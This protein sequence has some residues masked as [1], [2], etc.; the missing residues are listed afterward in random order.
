M[1]IT[2]FTRLQFQC[3][4]SLITRRCFLLALAMLAACSIG[5]M[6][7]R[8]S[9]VFAQT[10]DASQQTML[11]VTVS[12]ASFAPVV[13]P[14]SIAAAFG[15]RLA[16]RTE[17]AADRPLP[18]SLAGTT[19][20][21]N[22]ELAP[23]FFVSPGQ[24]NYLIP[25]GT[26]PGAASVVVTA[27]DGAVSTGSA[28]IGAVAPALFTANSDGQGA[29]ASL[30]YRVKANGQRIYEPLSRYDGASFVTRPIDFGAESDQLFLVLYL[31]GIRH[32]PLS[33]VRVSMGG[34]EY[35]PLSVGVQGGFDGLD[36]INVA[37]P[38]NFGGRGRIKLFIKAA[39]YG[40]SNVAEF[41]IGSGAQSPGTM[42]ISAPAQPVLAG[43][44]LEINGAG[45]A[46]NP[47]ENNVQIVA[48]DGVT[49]KAEVM[50]VSAT[51]IRIRV[52]FGA[53]TGQI[54]VSREQIEASAPIRVRTSVSGFVERAISQNGQITRVP[55]PGA[56]VRI[57]GRPETE[58]VTDAEGS[59]VLPDTPPS[60]KGEFEIL[61]PADGSLNF[62]P[63]KPAL[64]VYADR[65]NQFPRGDE[66]T[67]ISGVSFP[68][69]ADSDLSS[70]EAN[71]NATAASPDQNLTLTYLEPG[72]T[73]ANLPL[74]HFSTRIAQ[75]APFG[76]V[77]S[78]GARLS[79]PNADAIPVGA[80]A[81]LFK[82]DQAN[83]SVTLGQFV[84][85]GSATVTADGQRV[86]TAPNAITGGS[87][88][89]VSIT[90]PT[91]TINGRV[92]ESDGR[93]APRAIVQAR[94][95][96][97]FTDG[98][99][100]F[101]LNNV[102]VMK[103]SGDRVRVEVS[104]QRPSGR[105][106]RKDGNEVEL[107]AGALVTVKPDIAL[108]P[109]TTNFPPVILAPS[110]L[111]LSAGET[112]EFD[113]VVTDPDS[114][115]A[116]QVSMSGS[117]TTFT[118]LI[119]Q[120]SGVFRLRLAPGANAAGSYTLAL[121]AEDNTASVIQ[122]IAVTVAR[123]S[124]NA[125]TARNQAVTTPED[126]PRAIMLSGSAPSGRALGYA[127]VS[128]PSRGSLSG[129]AP[130]LAYT[131]MSN[132][133]GIDSFT[134]KVS[135]GGAESQPAT[136]FIAVSPVNDAPVLSV[137]G[138][139]VVNAGETLNLVVTATDVDGDQALQFTA[140]DLPPGATFKEVGGTS[141]LLNWTP[142]SAQEGVYTVSVTVKDKGSPALTATQAIRLTAIAQWAKT[143]GPEGGGRIYSL[144]N[145]GGI[146][147][148]GTATDGV[149]R[150][151]DNGQSWTPVNNGLSD[152]GL[153]V[154][155]LMSSGSDLYAGTF[156]GGL[157]R[158]TDNGQS[159]TP[160]KTVLSS[161]VFALLS[162]GG[163][164]FAG[165]LGGGIYR[166]TDG[167]QSW[168]PVNNGLSG[169]ALYVIALLSSESSLYAGTS[170]G[171]VYRSTDNGGSWVPVNRGFPPS[172]LNVYALLS[173]GSSLYAGTNSGVYR[174]TDNG[175][176][177]TPVNSGLSG[178][179]LEVDALLSSGSS[180]LAGTFGGGIYRSTDGGLSWKPVNNGLSG[181]RLFV[182]ALSSSGSSLFAG[183]FRGVYQSTDGGENWN[184]SSAGI[185]TTSVSALLN[186][187]NSMYAGTD[188]GG[189]Y[190]STD[191]GQSWTPTNNGLSD[192]GLSVYALLSS[193]SNLFAGTLEGV[194]RSTDDGQSW[195]PVNKG[196]SGSGLNVRALLSSGSS[197]FAGTNGGGIYRSTDDGQS[198]TPI[199]NGLSGSGLNVGALLSSGSSLFAGTTGGVYRSTD[200]G[201]SWMPVNN[202]FPNG[203]LFVLAL[204]SSGSSLFAGGFGGVYRSTDG[205][206]SWAPINNG[207]PSGE[208][209]VFALLS[210]G[211]SLYAGGL[212]GVYRS[213]DGGQ[214]WTRVGSGFISIV[215]SLAASGPRIFAGTSENSAWILADASQSWVENN[216]GLTNRFTNAI[217][218][219]GADIF[220]GTLGGGV[221]RSANQG[222]SW[223]PVNTGLPP[224]SNIQSIVTN[225]ATLWAATFGDGVYASDDRGGSWRAANN[226]LTNKFVNKLFLSGA[227]LYVGTDGGVFRSTNGGNSWTPVGL[228]NLRVV[229]FTLTNGTLYAGTDG[230]GVFRLNPESA[231]WTQVNR[232]LTSQSATALGASGGALYAG[233]TGG[234]ICISRDGGENWTAV[235][236]ALPADLNVFAF[237]VSGRKVYAGSIYGVFV[238]EDEGQSWKQINAGLLNTFV[239]GLA[240]SG[241]QLFASTASGGVFVSR[242]P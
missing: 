196:L 119:N 22:G 56:R 15:S 155:A 21:I 6:Q 181:R 29:L 70:A 233:T 212:D 226:G 191:G 140:I 163:G 165:T 61:P 183:T 101:V 199:N 185:L 134:F 38:G 137:P 122:S 64:R 107:T 1:R 116:P 229:S 168:T 19:V 190:R 59:F 162:S 214:S 126:T 193:G 74:S 125:P 169:N 186:H 54:K 43:D 88:Y 97:T 34:V 7:W 109:E 160:V 128:G 20:K 78:P 151:T 225:G 204:S 100:G 127:I 242:V 11:V 148:A 40:A 75:I 192:N 147:Y 117:A 92:V 82:F 5:V 87:Y 227:T 234:G 208:L 17:V 130:N 9:G 106:S 3:V 133:N 141:G 145:A 188:G 216:T 195:T 138:S 115:Q 202:G 105:V 159:W 84:E 156:D 104:Y 123:A 135:D 113:L 13:A 194:Y 112:R 108:D 69:L 239:T 12:A 167:G 210:S 98:F 4:N 120:G 177:W 224:N 172:G 96:S 232:G 62:P 139:Q 171:G 68:L 51:T 154:R 66:Q 118:T 197:L 228:T 10:T 142:T 67:I 179:G 207:F 37:L 114:G 136:V 73:P 63:K 219:S 53:G 95:Q 77:I 152:D 14:D 174:S 94:G 129:T 71:A 149:Y 2:W 230:G 184:L 99:G 111:T 58:R 157:Y 50:A 46:A 175:Q 237:A 42:Q 102:P 52:P 8:R 83:G 57:N 31:T 36:Q 241:D 146:L 217:V 206:Q 211:S 60:L 200:D 26:P 24:I 47:R 176:S 132:F 218:V 27:G 33:G 150:S 65:D 203:R 131:P 41:E 25:P 166:S 158:S 39:G 32:A 23:L 103:A 201:Q 205:G 121:R 72:R 209:G 44:E 173:S 144:L 161:Q 187:P 236:N 235:N 91:A 45:F 79:F 213:T 220:V 76:R 86:E 231:S 93:P 28:Q 170:F 164:L 49:A 221:F 240:V 90:R 89:F 180:L 55:I 215:H 110:N 48:D 143:S 238:T 178:R 189:V 153:D 223:S 198:W 30:L 222:Q 18:T 85:I 124:N 81:K 35:A 182:L 16:T 80:P